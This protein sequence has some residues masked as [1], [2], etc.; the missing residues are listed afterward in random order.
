MDQHVTRPVPGDPLPSDAAVGE[1]SGDGT[2]LGW[3]RYDPSLF[4]PTAPVFRDLRTGE[5]DQILADRLWPYRYTLRIDRS[6]RYA[7]WA[8]ASY[9]GRSEE[10]V[11]DRSRRTVTRLDAGDGAIASPAIS[12]TGR[13]VSV[14]RGPVHVDGTTLYVYDRVRHRSRLVGTGWWMTLARSGETGVVTPL[15]QNGPYLW[16]PDSPW[17]PGLP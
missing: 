17:V 7:V 2:V 16:I 6:G 12:A 5:D 8:G 1:L 13:Y 10:V 11:V 4:T 9:D 15:D 14:F 3:Y